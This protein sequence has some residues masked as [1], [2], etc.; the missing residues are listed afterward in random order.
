MHTP[1][2]KEVATSFNPVALCSLVISM[3]PNGTMKLTAMRFLF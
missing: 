2:G 1:F 3:A